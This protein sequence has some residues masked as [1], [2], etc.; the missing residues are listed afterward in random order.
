MELHLHVFLSLSHTNTPLFIAF[1]ALLL[2]THAPP[3]QLQKNKEWGLLWSN[4]KSTPLSK[5]RQ[6]QRHFD[7]QVWTHHLLA[8]ESL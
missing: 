2:L 8:Q 3:E 6:E 5:D 4:D 1:C 7:H